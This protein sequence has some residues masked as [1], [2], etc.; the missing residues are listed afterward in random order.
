ML[1]VVLS[2]GVSSALVFIVTSGVEVTGWEEPCG[3]SSAIATDGA[4]ARSA[5]RLSIARTRCI[6]TASLMVLAGISAGTRRANDARSAVALQLAL[7]VV[8][9]V[10]GRLQVRG[11]AV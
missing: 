2:C 11:Y 4:R 9:Q 10:H 3:L 7:L 1:L 8:L 5:P 6:T